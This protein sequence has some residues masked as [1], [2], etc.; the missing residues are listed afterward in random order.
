ML[1][2]TAPENFTIKPFSHTQLDIRCTDTVENII[3]QFDPDLVI[4]A[5]AYTAVD[6]AESNQKLA[7][8]VNGMAP[9]LIAKICRIRR[10]RMVHFSTDHVFSGTVNKAYRPDDA[11]GP[12]NVY[13]RSKLAGEENIMTQFPEALIIRTSWVYSVGGSNFITSICSG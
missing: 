13:G 6:K 11:T 8:A 10:I 2:K 1:R 12:I 7:M 4:N 9:G 3:D 5:A